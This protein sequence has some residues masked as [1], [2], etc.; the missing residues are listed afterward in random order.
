[1]SLVQIAERHDDVKAWILEMLSNCIC[2]PPSRIVIHSAL[3]PATAISVV[4][5]EISPERPVALRC[6]QAK[7]FYPELP[8]AYAT[9]PSPPSTYLATCE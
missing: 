2:H 4:S 1:M 3:S 8:A 6:A 9:C 7:P 5:K